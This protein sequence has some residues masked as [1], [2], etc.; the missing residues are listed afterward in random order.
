[1]L[2]ADYQVR[3][4]LAAIHPTRRERV[5]SSLVGWCYQRND[6]RGPF[7]WLGDR[8]DDLRCTLQR[9]RCDKQVG[10]APSRAVLVPEDPA[11]S[12]CVI[13]ASSEGNEG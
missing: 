9:R 10:P 3:R 2:D 7:N 4:L 1:M 5:L 13:E 11:G 6:E 12:V 8:A